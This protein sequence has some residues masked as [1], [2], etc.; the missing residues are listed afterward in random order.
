MPEWLDDLAEADPAARRSR[1]DLQR[2]NAWMGNARLI[3]RHLAGVPTNDLVELGA[4]DGTLLLQVARRLPAGRVTL[5]DR[6][7]LPADGVAEEFHAL[8]W[9]VVVVQADAFAWLESEKTGAGR[10]ILANLFLHH[11]ADEPLRRLLALIAVRAG[12]FVACEPARTTR[13]RSGARL[14][15]LIGCSRVTCHDARI[16]VA[17]GFAG[18]ELSALWPRGEW[19]LYE[20]G[21]NLFSHLFKAAR[22]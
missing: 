3:A 7:V 10:V 6:Q 21:M 1:R 8:G 19:R 16:S 5:V 2:V 14:L 4:G 11:F 15:P 20:A 12:H 17:A 18:R 13:A 22:P 9:S